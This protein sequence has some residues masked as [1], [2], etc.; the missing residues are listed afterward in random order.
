MY[1]FKRNKKQW[2]K[3]ILELEMSEKVSKQGLF[4]KAKRLS[5]RKTDSTIQYLYIFPIEIELNL[6]LIL[7]LDKFTETCHLKSKLRTNLEVT[8]L[9]TPSHVPLG[10]SSW[11]TWYWFVIWGR[12]TED[13][14]K[15]IQ[16]KKPCYLVFP[17][18]MEQ[19]SNHFHI[20][21]CS[22]SKIEWWC[23]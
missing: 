11:A 10:A 5:S 22:A 6:F 23:Y 14:M 21:S 17:T 9:Q 7:T 15:K 18:C 13:L 8:S 4:F 20:N 19:T 16:S 3:T 12:N 1:V 2:R